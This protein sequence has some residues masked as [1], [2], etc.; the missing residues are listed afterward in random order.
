M[1]EWIKLLSLLLL[2]TI[3]SHK[4]TTLIIYARKRYD[5]RL[6]IERK[7]FLKDDKSLSE[8]QIDTF[9]A[10]M[11][12]KATKIHLYSGI[13]LN[14]QTLLEQRSSKSTSTLL[15]YEWFQLTQALA[16]NVPCS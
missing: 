13:S 5:I 2:L 16:L 14:V 15:M 11:F 6:E 4:I 9:S 1:Y 7:L 3:A 8:E 10:G 12:S